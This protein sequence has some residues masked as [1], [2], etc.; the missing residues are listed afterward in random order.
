M[1]RKELWLYRDLK[2]GSCHFSVTPIKDSNDYEYMNHLIEFDSYN[3]LLEEA[4]AMREAL[5]RAKQNIGNMCIY[6][7]ERKWEHE[8]KEINRAREAL[9]RF[10]KFLKE[11]G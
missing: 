1:K 6:P 2:T 4:K 5:L 8:T 10:D 3:R 11:E 7:E 9:D